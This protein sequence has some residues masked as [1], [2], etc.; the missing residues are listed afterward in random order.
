MTARTP[1]TNQIQRLQVQT[2]V[3]QYFFQ[4]L[5]N[6]DAYF[7][8]F[9]DRS[10]NYLRLSF[11]PSFILHGGKN[12]IAIRGNSDTMGL[13]SE[14]LI[15]AIDA[16]G[17][18]VKTQVYDL[19]DEAH[20]RVISVDITPETPPGD[21]ILTILGT[22]DVSP[23]GSSIP[24]A[25]QG[26]TNFRW[27]RTFTA[28]PKSSNSSKIIYNQYSKPVI[29]VKEI[30]KPFYNLT[31]NQNLS[32]S[33]SAGFNPTS[34]Y[35]LSSSYN[36]EAQV[37]YR[38]AGG[39]F[40]LTATQGSS[41]YLDFGGFTNDMEGG[42][43]IVREPVNPVPRSVNGYLSPPVYAETEDGDGYFDPLLVLPGNVNPGGFVKGAYLST[44][45]EVLSP[46]E[47]RV[48][49]PHTTMQGL[50]AAQYQEFEHFEFES[51]D[52]ELVWAES[53]IS[54]SADPTGS[55]GAPLNTSYAHVTFNSLEPLT[56]DVTRVKCYMKNH[57]AP[58]DWMLA[59]DNAVSA[60]ELLFR[61]DFEKTRAPIGDFSKWGVAHNGI[62]SVQTYWTASGVGTPNPSMSLYTQQSSA[63]NPPV[64]DNL[65]IGDNQQAWQLDGTAY[66]WLEAKQSAEFFQDQWYE[67]SMKAVSVKTQLPTWTTLATQPLVNPKMTVYMSG[68]SFTDGGDGHGKFIGLIEDTAVRKKHVEFDLDNDEKEVGYKFVFKADGTSTALPKFKIDSGVWHFWDISIK[69]WDRKGYTPGTWDVIFPTI[70]C[71]VGNFD[72]LDFKFEFY[73]DDGMISNYAAEINKIPWENELTATFTNVVSN[74]VTSSTGSFGSLSASTFNGPTTFSTGPFI[75]NGAAT[76]SSG[77]SASGPNILGGPLYLGSSCSDQVWLSGSVYIP[78]VT[79][80]AGSDHLMVM[81]SDHLVQT[82]S[83]TLGSVGGFTSLAGNTGVT[84]QSTTGQAIGVIGAGSISTNMIGNNVVISSTGAGQ[85][86][87]NAYSTF[88]FAG[89]GTSHPDMVAHETASTIQ[90]IGGCGIGIDTVDTSSGQHITINASHSFSTFAVPG[91]S[92]VLADTCQ[93]TVIFAAGSGMTITTTPASDTITFASSGGGDGGSV[94]GLQSLGW[95]NN[96]F[97]ACGAADHQTCQ[98]LHH[99]PSTFGNYPGP[100]PER[101]LAGQWD[102]YSEATWLQVNNWH[103]QPLT[104]WKDGYP[105]YS[106]IFNTTGAPISDGKLSCCTDANFKK[107]GHGI[108]IM[109]STL[110]VALSH[111]FL[112][113]CATNTGVAPADSSYPGT[114]SFGLA[115]AYLVSCFHYKA[116]CGHDSKFDYG[117]QSFIGGIRKD[118]NAPEDR[119]VFE[120]ISDK[121]RK[122]EIEPTVWHIQDLMKIRVRDFYYKNAKKED[123]SIK[124][125]GLIAQELGDIFPQA[126]N[127]D[128]NGDVVK[129]PMS[130][131]ISD[132]V[133]LLIK[134]VQDQQ[135]MIEKLEKRISK[136]ES[137]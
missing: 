34:S 135:H 4:D 44:I 103:A 42:I 119:I 37:K 8:D 93:D 123:R 116:F 70:K 113:T 60:Q 33:V 80:G 6:R 58:F 102:D 129:E 133:P 106:A 38:K 126:V 130:V 101:L 89:G 5:F 36:T 112:T 83:L 51:S 69:P 134:S 127:G 88:S 55:G 41:N 12:L 21:L 67:I 50:S 48:S 14:I 59:S 53:P 45:N 115:N 22:A 73:N 75:F 120:T 30:K 110:P 96:N 99:V 52:F 97:K 136:M 91:Q 43:I 137:K 65:M 84:Y 18:I 105:G 87:Q 72:S 74:T 104:K 100:Y 1:S 39:K 46:F 125:I 111:K 27:T 32:Q 68:S 10:G 121:R 62:A 9:D 23:D 132:L 15:E 90:W 94:C 85:S 7:E 79:Q 24:P 13:N 76:F 108:K 63:E 118:C 117:V 16:A 81:G 40:F 64:G 92:A 128:P 11:D 98:N 114:P 78:C 49:T 17:G 28:K 20:N 107:A 35:I 3:G 57:Q 131:V 56:G 82:S 95:N 86:N 122:T 77:V 2:Q 29:S 54:Y 31:Y 71:N 124:N 25:W 47:A 66:W 19:N 61:R 109:T 26:I